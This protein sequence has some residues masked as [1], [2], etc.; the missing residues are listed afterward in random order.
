M[1]IGNVLIQGTGEAAKWLSDVFNEAGKLI[2]EQI[3]KTA[4][5]VWNALKDLTGQWSTIVGEWGNI[6]Y[7]YITGTF[8]NFKNSITDAIEWL[9]SEI[10]A[11][12][13]DIWNTL[14][15]LTGQWN[16][17]VTEWGNIAWDFI[18]KT[19]ADICDTLGSWSNMITQFGQIAW[20]QIAHTATQVLDTIGGW[21]NTITEFGQYM[22]QNLWVGVGKTLDDLIYHYGF[23]DP[24]VDF[25]KLSIEPYKLPTSAYNYVMNASFEYGDW[26]G[27]ESLQTSGAAH[28]N[29]FIR[30]VAD[31]TDQVYSG[32][33]NYIDIRG[34][35][36]I[37]ITAQM[38]VPN[39]VKGNANARV[40]FYDANKD[41]CSEDN[42]NNWKQLTSQTGEWHKYSKTYT[43]ADDFPSDCAFVRLR[44]CWYYTDLPEGTFD[45][46]AVQVNF[47]DQ[48]PAFQDFTVYSYN[49]MPEKI[50]TNKS[51]EKAWSSD[52]SWTDILKIENF[53]CESKMLL[54]IF[55][56]A[57]TWVTNDGSGGRGCAA[58]LRLKIDGNVLDATNQLVGLDELA[59]NSAFYAPYSTHAVSI[60]SKGTHTLTM[61]MQTY[62]VFQTAKVTDRRLTILKG[63][64]KGGA[65]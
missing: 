11:T 13:D 55:S 28:G 36:K 31:G 18:T 43:I 30:L 42:W 49:W 53:E 9:W 23:S 4:N 19:Y 34:Y 59:E 65:T 24:K 64:Y 56:H 62:G 46:D 15:N 39:Y 14:K 16:T 45:I 2:W 35:D 58:K 8:E 37:T 5:D 54:L 48:I 61:E 44:F 22:G 10:S 6:L 38:K 63:F 51:T 27:D 26:G 17:M 47:G 25:E 29:K 52:T 32:F 7:E 12:A 60:Q 57:K 50:E 1:Q 40:W 3:T 33:S 21:T 20:G 41:V